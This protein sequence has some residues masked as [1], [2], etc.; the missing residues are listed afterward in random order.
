M[1]ADLVL[2]ILIVAAFGAM[3]GTGLVTLTRLR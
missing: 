3:V 2:W 1:T